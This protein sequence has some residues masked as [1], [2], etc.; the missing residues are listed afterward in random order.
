MPVNKVRRNGSYAPLSAH[1]YKDAALFA[2]GERAEVLFTRSLAFC[3]DVLNDGFIAENQLPLFT[4]GLTGVKARADKLLAGCAAQAHDVADCEGLWHRET[5]RGGYVVTA[6]LKWN[7]SKKEIIEAAEKDADR[8]RPGAP[9]DRPPSPDSKRNPDGSGTESDRPP[10][11]F[12]P[13]ARTPRHSTTRNSTPLQVSDRTPP[14]PVRSET[15]GGAPPPARERAADAL[16]R[17]PE[18]HDDKGDAPDGQAARAQIASL[19]SGRR[20]ADT[21]HWRVGTAPVG[22]PNPH[23]DPTAAARLRA[24]EDPPEGA[25]A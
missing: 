2:A 10:K 5:A 19:L 12:Q 13:R 25:T 7:R 24:V 18:P 22:D 11:G 16:A 8:K 23:Y 17:P 1:Y 4:V 3:S 9:P 21:R 6:W 14:G 20:R 15:P